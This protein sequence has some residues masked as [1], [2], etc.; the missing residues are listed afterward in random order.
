[1]QITINWNQNIV[2]FGLPLVLI[3][4]M[5]LLTQTTIFQLHPE[6][7]SIGI[8]FDL[9]L[10]VPLVYFLL[11][12]KKKIPKITIVPLFVA[13]IV[14]A[15]IIIPMDNQFYL[16]QIK[17]WVLPLVETTALLLIFFKVRKTVKLY[18]KQ[19]TVTLDFYTALKNATLQVLPARI[20]PAFTTEIAVFYYGFFNWKKR[21]LKNNEFSYHRKSGT[22]AL[23]S[24]FIFLILFETSIVHIL[25]QRWSYTV[26]WIL[27]TLSSYTALQVFGII[28]SMSK[29]PIIIENRVLKLR[30]GLFSESTIPLKN[31]ESVEI[32]GRAIELDDSTRK[33]SPLREIENHNV[34]LILKEENT[35]D[36]LYGLKKRYK[37]VAFHIDEKERFEEELKIALK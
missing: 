12:R 30:Y 8:T 27:T 2:T 21:V 10:T 11:I 6:V 9:I 16:T 22:I 4:F 29:R 7:L 36:G 1:M 31:I 25:L 15:S 19:K 5:V 33:L 32:S 37:T 24:V 35:I 14:I 28:R 17:Y 23:L 34:I 18:K 13:G 3:L 20:A 26:A